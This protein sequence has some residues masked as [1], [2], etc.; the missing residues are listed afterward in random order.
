MARVCCCPFGKKLSNKRG[1][2]WRI[3]PVYEVMIVLLS[4]VLGEQGAVAVPSQQKASVPMEGFHSFHVRPLARG[5]QQQRHDYY[6]QSRWKDLGKSGLPWSHMK[7]V[8]NGSG[9]LG[10]TL[11]HRDARD[12]PFRANL[13]A[14]QQQQRAENGAAAVGKE[15]DFATIFHNAVQRDVV[16]VR[17]IDSLLGKKTRKRLSRRVH[18]DGPP[19]ETPLFSGQDRCSSLYN[20]KSILTFQCVTF[21]L[22][23]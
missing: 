12:S 23:G 1:P 4:L 11:V 2:G 16:R 22:V 10:L 5:Q 15:A 20:S 13:D 8:R 9:V 3:S 17:A 7:A 6:S 21:Q 14:Q 18:G 19:L